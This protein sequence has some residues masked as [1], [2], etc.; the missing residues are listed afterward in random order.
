[1]QFSKKV[2]RAHEIVLAGNFLPPG[3]GLATPVLDQPL[4]TGPVHKYAGYSYSKK[5]LTKVQG[6]AHLQ[7]GYALFVQ[8]CA[9]F[10]Q[11]D[12]MFAYF[13]MGSIQ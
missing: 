12:I 2:W 6:C 10:M 3:S 1:M 13:T 11:A 5:L 4:N 7:K 9:K 8:S